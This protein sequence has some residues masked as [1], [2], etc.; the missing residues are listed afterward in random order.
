MC[1]RLDGPGDVSLADVSFASVRRAAARLSDRVHRTPLLTCRSLE[2]DLNVRGA[3]GVRVVLKAEHLQ[4]VGAF[5]ARGASNAVVAALEAGSPPGFLTHSSGNHGA[6]LAW[7]ARDVGVPCTVVVPEDAPAIKKDAMR[8]YGAELVECPRPERSAVCDRLA[9][10]R[11]LRVVPPFDD[12]DVI[13]GQATVALEILEDRSEIDVIIA[14]VGGGGLL[15]GTTVTVRALCGDAVSVVGAEPAA[16][17]DAARSLASGRLERP[18]PGAR[19]LCD[20]LMTA[21]SE[22]TFTI[23]RD[24][25]A[26]IDTVADEEVLS[27]GRF[28]VTRTKQWVE[29]SAAVAWAVARRIAPRLAGRTTAVVIT[30]G[31]APTDWMVEL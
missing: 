9:A 11:G 12:P 14:P 13:A 10:E 8:G 28:L 23:L 15:S 25:R 18:E 26:T 27:A 20:G 17:D 1:A 30:G 6:A 2:A 29:P 4:K 22:R 21:L 7:A 19:T 5:K 16:V 24:G 31:N 3:E